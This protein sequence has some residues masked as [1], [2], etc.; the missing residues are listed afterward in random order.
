[1]EQERIIIE[2][3][4]RKE[5]EGSYFL[6]PFEVPEDVERIDIAYEYPRFREIRR[7]GK[8]ERTEIN[9]VDLGV[10]GPNEAYIGS[11]G[12]DRSEIYI[13][14]FESA[15][16]F[17]PYRTV[18]GTWSVIAGAYKVEEQG[19]TCRYEITFTRKELRLFKG[20]TH[21]HTTG[22]DGV[23]SVN[24]LAEL[25]ANMGLDY[26]VITDHNNY[27][28][29]FQGVTVPGITV[30]PGTE[31]THYKGHAGLLGVKKPFENAFCVNSKEEAVEKLREAG[32]NGALI[33]LNHPFCPNCGWKWGMEGFE[34]DVIEL[35]NGSPLVP[36]NALCMEW[37]HENLCKGRR[38]PVIGGSDFHRLDVMSLPSL[39]CTCIYA[40]SREQEDLI[41]AMRL[42]H[43]YLSLFGKG[44]DLE[45]RAGEGILGDTVPSGTECRFRFFRLSA[46]DEICLIT[47]QKTERQQCGKNVTELTLSLT[48]PGAKFVRAE[49][50]RTFVPGMPALPVLI[51][52]PIY[53][54]S[55]QIS[56]GVSE[57]NGNG[58]CGCPPETGETI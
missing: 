16:G 49:V 3:F 8:T 33:V 57:S 47:D 4:I 39:P 15:Q 53:F 54:E 7:D 10:N 21:M 11:S 51:S 42:G 12:S 31:W 5:E 25:C 48:A 34:Y 37:W 17:A 44:P 36:H 30:I 14:S 50:K 35:M 56:G 58:I 43:C 23:F 46:G 32:K 29:N 28:H 52:N 2:R 9:I 22:S 18:S 19:V 1:M 27:S 41:E 26:I 40:K 24:D 13:S 38:I 45:M 20:D 6:I 55:E